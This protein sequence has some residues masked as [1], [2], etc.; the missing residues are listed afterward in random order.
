LQ[1]CERSRAHAGAREFARS[2]EYAENID[3]S[4]AS[5]SFRR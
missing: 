4:V 2:A 3:V 5:W 1:R